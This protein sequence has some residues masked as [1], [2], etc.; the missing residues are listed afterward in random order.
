M[1][2]CPESVHFP[3]APL[4]PLGFKPPS[5]LPWV[6]AV[7]SNLVSCLLPFPTFMGFQPSSYDV[8]V[9]TDSQPR[10][11]FASQSF[12]NDWR[13]FW[14]SQQRELLLASAKQPATVLQGTREQL[15]GP[16]WSPPRLRNPMLKLSHHV[17]LY[18]QNLQWLLVSLKL[19]SQVAC[20]VRLPVSSA[21]SPAVT[22]GSLYSSQAGL[23][24]P[25][26]D[27]SS[28]GPFMWFLLVPWPGLPLPRKPWGSLSLFN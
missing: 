19:E 28:S 6:I 21:L 13:H 22:P 8:P 26:K 4:L 10:G 20:M 16:K 2:I 5:A 17:I 9:K 15:F 23:A 14:S 11:D 12:G 3:S 18:S 7:V 1:K 24:V 27:L 25:G